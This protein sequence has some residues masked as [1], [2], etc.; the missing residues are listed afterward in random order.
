MLK[1][2]CRT[3]RILAREAGFTR[4]L[5]DHQIRL[6][7]AGGYPSPP[8]QQVNMP[9]FRPSLPPVLFVGIG[10]ALFHRGADSRTIWN[11][12]TYSHSYPSNKH[13]ALQN[14]RIES[15]KWHETK[16][17]GLAGTIRDNVPSM[18][19]VTP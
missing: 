11:L 19:G 4:Q 8:G 9:L 2:C 17:G 14:R 18:Y 15:A 10:Q 12:F 7:I 16:D 1:R 6:A 3:S 5:I 13:N